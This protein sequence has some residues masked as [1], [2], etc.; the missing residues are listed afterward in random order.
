MGSPLLTGDEVAAEDL[1]VEAL[2]DHIW[3]ALSR[4]EALHSFVRAH[5]IDTTQP[6]QVFIT[7]EGKRVQAE[8]YAKEVAARAERLKDGYAV[9]PGQSASPGN[10]SAIS[11]SADVWRTLHQLVVEVTKHLADTT[12]HAPAQH[13]PL[14]KVVWHL[15]ILIGDVEDQP[16]LATTLR[17]LRRLR[18]SASRVVD[19]EQRQLLDAPCPWCGNNT[20]VL[21]KVDGIARCERDRKKAL[22]C[23]C[24]FATCDCK[25]SPV[26]HQHTWIRENGTKRD[27]WWGLVD[28]QA[29]VARRNKKNATTKKE[30]TR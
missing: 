29:A 6:G 21:Y 11:V 26:T 28:Q 30:P 19:G 12:T 20:I 16:L 3:E 13:D 25:R 27:G 1:S 4:I 18:D 22:P 10:V 15:N 14:H 8:L 9:G 24:D 23:V 2:R 5:L 17:T 7:A